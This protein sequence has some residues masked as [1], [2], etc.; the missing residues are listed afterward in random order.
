MIKIPKQK[1]II[2]IW[3]IVTIITALKQFL[4]S[5]KAL[6]INDFLNTKINNYLIFKNVFFHTLNE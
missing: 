1:I 6:L 2:S 4:V 3:V 5:Q